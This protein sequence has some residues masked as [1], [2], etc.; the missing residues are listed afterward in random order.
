MKAVRYTSIL[1]ALRNVITGEYATEYDEY[2]KRDEVAVFTS[3]LEARL[4]GAN[5]GLGLVR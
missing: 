1:W 4:W 5:H 2:T 3:P